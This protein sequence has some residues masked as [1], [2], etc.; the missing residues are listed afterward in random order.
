MQT[1]YESMYLC[2]TSLSFYCSFICLF[3]PFHVCQTL[4]W[5]YFPSFSQED[6]WFFRM[7]GRERLHSCVMTASHLSSHHFLLS[8]SPSLSHTHPFNLSLWRRVSLLSHSLSLSYACHDPK[9]FLFTFNF[10]F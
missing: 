3:V 10:L 7:L 4:S 6:K 8:L 1:I 9:A 5:S 2:L